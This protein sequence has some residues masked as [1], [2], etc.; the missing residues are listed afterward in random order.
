MTPTPRPLWKSPLVL[1]T[2]LAAGFVTLRLV[3]FTMGTAASEYAL[4]YDYGDAARETSLGQ[5][6][7][8][9]NIEYPQLAV[10]FGTAA[11]VVADH[12]PE[13]ADR[14]TSARP[15][16]SFGRNY[17]RYEAALGLVLA[18]VD[19]AC[20]ALVY[21]IGRRIYPNES[22]PRRALRLLVY[23]LATGALG[24]ILYDR[25]DPVVALVALVAL[26][27]LIRGWSVVGYALLTLG[28]AYKLV[29][30]LLLPV[31][32][33]AAAAV[34]CAPNATPGRFLRATL[35]EAAIGFVVL[36]AWPLL[37]YEFGG[38]DRAFVFLTFH[39]AR[40]LQLEAPAAWPT[41]LLD[42]AAEVGHGYGSYNFRGPLADRVAGLLKGAM[43]LTAGLTV[44][45]AGRGFWSAAAGP[46]PV[47]PVRL[48]PHVVASALL[49]WLGFILANKV[50]SPQYLLWVA[51]LMPLLPFRTAREW[52]W[53]GLMLVVMVVT[54]AVYPCAYTF[55]MGE[56]L[57]D[58]PATWAGPNLWAK[59]LLTVKS[60]G[61][62][63]ATV[64]LGVEVWRAGRPQPAAA[65]SVPLSVRSDR[66]DADPAP[67][68]VPVG[69][70]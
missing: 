59:L 41:I 26:Y 44:L 37:T 69:P 21:L 52:W 13:G 50:G 70:A 63:A 65:S 42:P 12:L 3:L 29:P 25:Q 58:D 2:A 57:H 40:G 5:L 34:R 18:G 36:A 49:V 9:R 7:H 64:W 48:G 47:P 17:A 20:L 43:I 1:Y 51:P 53:T 24:F 10:L 45:I 60:I 38:R 4:Y 27:T 35:I 23:T 54:T 19:L 55:V 28:T 16:P 11:G 56:F 30:A 62:A 39:T 67:C 61:L 14:W 22:H 66:H 15:N 32:V 46:S 6:Y 68:P 31:W 33:F 8:D